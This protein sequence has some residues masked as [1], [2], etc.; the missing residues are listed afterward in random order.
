MITAPVQGNVNGIP[1]RSHIALS[2]LLL[3]MAM[4]CKN[5]AVS[6]DNRVT[7]RSRV[8]V[9]FAPPDGPAPLQYVF[10][11]DSSFSLRFHPGKAPTN[12][13]RLVGPRSSFS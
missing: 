11:G 13:K 10:G 9:I 2:F 7:R 1:K 8:T 6:P 4:V 5:V 12:L 3:G